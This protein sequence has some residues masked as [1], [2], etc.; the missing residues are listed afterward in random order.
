[1]TASGRTGGKPL[2]VPALR[3]GAGGDKLGAR[4]RE[5]RMVE[6]GAETTV[7]RDL[8][9][10]VVWDAERGRQAYL[11]DAEIEFAGTAL[12]YVGPRRDGPPPPGAH[13]IDG[14]GRL[15]LPGFVNVHSHPGGEP[16]NKGLTEEK[17]SLR[18]GMSSL[19]EFMPLI[20]AD[21]DG[22]RAAAQLAW[23]ELLQ[24]GVTTLVDYWPPRPH[25]LE[26][27]EVSGLRGC[28]APMYR[29]ARWLTRDGHS[30]DYEWDEGAGREA[31]AAALELVDAA[32]AHPSGRLFGM[33]AP[34]QIDTCSEALLQA[35]LEAARARGL[36]VQ[37]HAAQSVVEFQEMT[38]RHGLSPLAWLEAIGFLCADAIIAH[39]IFLDH[40]DWIFWPPGGDLE[41]LAASGAGVAH[42]PNVFVRRGILLQ[43]FG[44]YRRLGIEIGI[45]T[46]S[47]PHNFLDELRWAAT[48]CKVAGAHV[49]ATDLAQV[50]EA[51]TLGGARLLKRDDLGR[52]APGCKA[53]LVLADLNHPAMRPLHDPLKSLVFSALERPVTDVF[54]DGRRVVRDGRV[55]TI[56]VAAAAAEVDRAQRDALSRVQDY[57]YAGRDA[58]AL[59]PLTLPRL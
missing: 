9:W 37:L 58:A 4:A 34:A 50:F 48:L 35:S 42:C 7:I 51:G 12:T 28:V 59:F 30:L 13:R 20:R 43:D 17:G 53:D 41:R 26:D 23:A 16:F 46:D 15:A 39:C 3:A 38:R 22:T 33:V 10:A 40:H 24:S 47:F 36:P 45:G 44:R 55:T 56:D 21:E 5:T 49:E 52:L 31:M 27:L 8:D 6:Q 14:R 2:Y 54:V 25:W 32:M 19:Y 18:L 11:R 57:D 1:M 29:S